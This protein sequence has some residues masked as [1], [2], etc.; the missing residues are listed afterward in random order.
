MINQLFAMKETL[1]LIRHLLQFYR[2]K[3]E[4]FHKQNSFF[5]DQIFFI[6]SF[7]LFLTQH[8]FHKFVMPSDWLL[9]FGYAMW[10]IWQATCHANCID[11]D[12]YRLDAIPFCIARKS[13]VCW[14]GISWIWW[15][16]NGGAS[17]SNKYC[18]LQNVTWQ[19][20]NRN[21]INISLWYP[22]SDVRGRSHAT[23]IPWHAGINRYHLCNYWYIHPI[24]SRHLFYMAWSGIDFMFYANFHHCCIIFCPRKSLLAA[25]QRSYRS[26]KRIAVLVNENIEEK[27]FN[28]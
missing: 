11:S 28:S 15:W 7:H 17:K 21:F 23:T 20:F 14:I 8:R 24:Y 27:W 5:T 10:T 6:L 26:G 25:D 13:S 16:S 3:S 12:V 2:I 18:K 1:K 19:I 22:G 9:L 4:K